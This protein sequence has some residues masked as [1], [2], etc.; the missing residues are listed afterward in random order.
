M[1]LTSIDLNFKKL[2]SQQFAKLK[3][4]LLQSELRSHCNLEVNIVNNLKQ[5]IFTK[6]V[7]MSLNPRS[8]V[9][10]PAQIRIDMTSPLNILANQGYDIRIPVSKI[11]LTVT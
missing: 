1:Q 4:A 6:S 11:Q 8:L 5:T 9:V 7:R 3:K 2:T 10:E